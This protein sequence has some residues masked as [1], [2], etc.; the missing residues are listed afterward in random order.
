MTHGIIYRRLGSDRPGLPYC[1]DC[2]AVVAEGRSRELHTNYYRDAD[3]A[4]AP[5]V[6]PVIGTEE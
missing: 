4:Q 3:G 1:G 6:I 2:G 5:A